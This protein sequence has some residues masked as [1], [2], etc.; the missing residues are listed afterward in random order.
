MVKVESYLKTRRKTI[1]IIPITTSIPI[2]AIHRAQIKPN[3]INLSL[4]PIFT[5]Q[6]VNVVRIM[7]KN[8]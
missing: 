1:P 6:V 8:Q 7:S 2:N 5:F 3:H 4:Y